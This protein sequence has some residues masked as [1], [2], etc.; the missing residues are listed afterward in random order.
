MHNSAPRQFKG[1]NHPPTQVK[2]HV[3]HDDT[4]L[5]YL[6]TSEKLA[7]FQILCSGL[8]WFPNILSFRVSGSA[9]PCRCVSLH[10]W[11]ARPN[12]NPEMF[13]FAKYSFS[14][15]NDLHARKSLTLI[16]LVQVHTQVPSY[17]FLLSL[18]IALFFFSSRVQFF[19]LF[20]NSLH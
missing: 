15:I 20:G 7:H 5:L 14:I 1:S 2:A 12:P 9:L 6:T 8:S 3:C 10:A 11:L 16:N 19:T 13:L 4:T 17:L 18:L